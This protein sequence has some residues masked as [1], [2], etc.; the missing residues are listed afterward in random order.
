MTRL[1]IGYV[2]GLP[3]EE[4][5]MLHELIFVLDDKTQNNYE[6]VI[7]YKGKNYL[8]DLGIS[9]P[10]SLKGLHGSVGWAA[11]AVDALAVRSRFDGFAFS[12]GQTHDIDSV[13]ATNFFKSKYQQS[14]TSELINSCAF[15][16]VSKGGEDEPPVIV[17]AYSALN[18]SAVWDFRKNRIKYG[19]V[20]ADKQ[21]KFEASNELEP[22]AVNLYTNTDIWEITKK[23]ELWSAKRLPHDMGRPLMEALVYRPS[24]DRPFG[25][26]RITRD[27]MEIVD[28]ATRESVRTEIH[29]EFFT[30]PQRV[31]LGVDP[32]DVFSGKSEQQA[33]IGSFLALG[34]DEEGEVPQVTQFSQ[35][36]MQPHLDYMKSLALRF[37]AMTNVPVSEMG[38]VSD[39]PSSADAILAAKEGLVLEAEDLN[40]SNGETLKSIGRMAIS[41]LQ[42]KPLSELTDV[43][44]SIAP[45]FKSPATPSIV[46][47]ADAW[48]KLASSTTSE[49]WLPKT[50]IYWEEIGLPE[51]KV[52][53]V[54]NYSDEQTRKETLNT[55]ANAITTPA[56][57]NTENE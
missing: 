44:N 27:V 47:Q 25:R 34:R 46:S 2:D 18:A 37:S 10:Q 15:L 32:N 8:K 16:T 28:N 19:L 43:E 9:I 20:V 1:Q 6:R 24:L 40:A 22:T 7:Y 14:V 12:D 13:F 26:S 17:N 39:N 3:A 23:N 52:N 54:M 55:I 53:R 11:K 50:P 38:V 41:I 33:L 21:K 57:T 4:T 36:S 56:P 49:S 30:S 29:S 48:V 35:A 51:E 31:I 5:D 42:N 45:R